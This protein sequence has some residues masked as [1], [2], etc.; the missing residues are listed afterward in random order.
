MT[1]LSTVRRE[2]IWVCKT[3][4]PSRPSSLLMQSVRKDRKC[5]SWQSHLQHHAAFWM[6]S[7]YLVISYQQA[8]DELLVHSEAG[9]DVSLQDC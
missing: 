5:K 9:P 7:M 4:K 3:S 2:Q 8:S 6:S 1:F